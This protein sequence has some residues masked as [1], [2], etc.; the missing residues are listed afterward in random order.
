LSIVQASSFSYNT[1]VNIRQARTKL[2]F[3]KMAESPKDHPTN[4]PTE[5][6][7]KILLSLSSSSDL[8]AV[9]NAHPILRQVVEVRAP[10]ICNTIILSQF[11]DMERS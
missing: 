10:R 1:N 7:E 8:Y 9:A 3:T 2:S 5:I 4:L 6:I 11:A